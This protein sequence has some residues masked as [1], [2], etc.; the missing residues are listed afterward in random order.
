MRDTQKEAETYTKGEADS[1][2]E[3]DTRLDPRTLGSHPE[4][5]ADA[6]S[7][8]HPV[9]PTSVVYLSYNWKIAPLNPFAYFTR[10]TLSPLAATDSFSLMFFSL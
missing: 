2:R 9:A 8:S 1:C 4:L 5:K 7:L 6:Q 10:P 3:P